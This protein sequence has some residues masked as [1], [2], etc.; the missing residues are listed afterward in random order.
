MLGT[1]YPVAEKNGES[2]VIPETL[3]VKWLS[4]ECLLRPD[5]TY[6]LNK[7][8]KESLKV[9]LTGA[10]VFIHYQRIND[11]FRFNTFQ[12]TVTVN[13]RLVSVTELRP[14]PVGHKYLAG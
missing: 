6:L 4:I 14:Y 2:T 7:T 13:F 3:S 8:Q 1:K 11:H 5:G 9:C 10:L 12:S